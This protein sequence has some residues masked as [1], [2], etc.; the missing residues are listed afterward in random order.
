MFD[1]L[2]P[3]TDNLYKFVAISGLAIFLFFTWSRL[4]IGLEEDRL[5]R[6]SISSQI[7]TLMFFENEVPRWRDFTR[8]LRSEGKT[9]EEISEQLTPVMKESEKNPEFQSLF[10]VSSKAAKQHMEYLERVAA[11]RALYNVLIFVGINISVV[12]FYFWWVRVQKP[13]DELLKLQLAK[14]RREAAT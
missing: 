9:E 1:K 7:D 6:R 13:S 14:A 2:S 12:G 10:A 5:Q 8:K 11:E 4:Q 3:P